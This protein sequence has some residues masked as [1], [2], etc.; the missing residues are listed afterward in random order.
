M[1]TINEEPAIGI[2]TYS[3]EHGWTVPSGYAWPKCYGCGHTYYSGAPRLLVDGKAQD[4][5]EC[6]WCAEER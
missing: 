4:G 2:P 5:G 1:N 3:R 6:R